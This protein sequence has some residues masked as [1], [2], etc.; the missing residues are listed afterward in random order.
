MTTINIKL[1]SSYAA[2]QN[3]TAI[4]VYGG[5]NLV[6]LSRVSDK[7]AGDMGH[8]VQ[9]DST[10]GQWY[11]NT[12]AGND[13]YTALTQVGVQTNS[14]L[15]ARTEPSFVKRIS[16]TRSLDEKI[17]KLRVVI[18]KEVNN[19]KNPESGFIIQESSTTGLRT[20]ADSFF[21]PSR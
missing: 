12:N 7:E 9:Y 1:A 6:I 17:Y 14:G 19:G 8:P 5:T 20:D 15:D 3:D 13:I 10:Q 2:S 21:H 16:D 18:P 11:I 4:T